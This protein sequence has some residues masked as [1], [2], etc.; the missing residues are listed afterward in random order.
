MRPIQAI[1]ERVLFFTLI[2]FFIL[3]LIPNQFAN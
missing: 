3:K 2:R 1:S